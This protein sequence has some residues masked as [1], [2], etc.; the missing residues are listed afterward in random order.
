MIVFAVEASQHISF[1]QDYLQT[2]FDPAHILSELGFT[3]VFDGL[4]LAL[5]GK[6]IK[7]YVLKTAHQEHQQHS[8]QGTDFHGTDYM[9]GYPL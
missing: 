3:A 8:V 5:G 9:G 6:C 7:R 4:I 1:W 2:Q